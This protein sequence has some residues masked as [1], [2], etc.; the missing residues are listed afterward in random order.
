MGDLAA[1]SIEEIWAHH[2]LMPAV[3]YYH[4]LV[5]VTGWWGKF[6]LDAHPPGTLFKEFGCVLRFHFSSAGSCRLF[7]EKL[8]WHRYLNGVVSRFLSVVIES[9]R[10]SFKP[11]QLPDE[12]G[13]FIVLWKVG[14]A[15]ERRS[16]MSNTPIIR[17][18]QILRVIWTQQASHGALP[19]GR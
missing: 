4:Q 8:F 13:T 5:T 18:R 6:S 3:T 19:P 10:S 9:S 16:L 14:R 1:I 2:V 17:T 7:R 12:G 11:E 15:V